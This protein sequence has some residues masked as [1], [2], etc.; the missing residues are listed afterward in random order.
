MLIDR[1]SPRRPFQFHLRSLLV[2][3]T[4]TCVVFSGIGQ[5]G[6]DGLIERL[7]AAFF[8]ASP[9]VALVEAYCKW[10]EMGMDDS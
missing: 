6:V 2:F 10:K 9:F 8:I 7:G 5:F 1:P 3:M 4:V